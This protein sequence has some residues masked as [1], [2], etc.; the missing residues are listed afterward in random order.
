MPGIHR[1]LQSLAMATA[2]EYDSAQL[3][4]RKSCN[5]P[6]AARKFDVHARLPSVTVARGLGRRPVPFEPLDRVLGLPFFALDSLG[7]AVG[8]SASS[9]PMSC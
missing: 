3:N 2:G 9:Q 1:K 4:T 6:S 7:F 5:V 8:L